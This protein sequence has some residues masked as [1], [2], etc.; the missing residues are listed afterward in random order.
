LGFR[1]IKNSRGFTLLEL[2]VTLI[3]IGLISTIIM[4]NSN[5]LQKYQSD[6]IQSYVS[7]I[8]YLTEESALTK[9]NIGWFIGNEA[10]FI[11][12]YQNNEW[13][14]QFIQPN[15][16]PE[17]KST[18]KFLDNTG[19][20]FVITDQSDDPFIVFYPSGQSSGGSVEFNQPDKNYILRIDSYS[21]VEILSKG[22]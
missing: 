21:A 1:E 14:P 9:K 6:Q 20:F 22:R 7:F 12:S 10:Q 4:T 2:L 13:S 16:F 11:S 8:E 19:N 15:F 5:F 3:L 17:I 18:T